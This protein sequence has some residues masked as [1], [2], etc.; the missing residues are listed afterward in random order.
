MENSIYL[1]IFSAYLSWYSSHVSQSSGSSSGTCF[2][3]L[4]RVYE[5]LPGKAMN[6]MEH[7]T[8]GEQKPRPKTLFPTTLRQ[9]LSITRQL[10]RGTRIAYFQ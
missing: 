1:N 9:N 7:V 4:A 8:Y 6:G 10:Q 3:G 2:R 5:R